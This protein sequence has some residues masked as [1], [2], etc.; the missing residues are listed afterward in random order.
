MEVE[1]SGSV[2]TLAGALPLSPAEVAEAFLSEPRQ[3]ERL[4]AYARH[5]FGIGAEECQDLIQETAYDVLRERRVV[6]NPAGFVFQVFHLRCCKHLER[7]MRR[8]KTFVPSV[9]PEDGAPAFEAPA[10]PI[11]DP[12][13]AIAVRRAM[14]SVS[15]VCQKILVAYYIEGY[16]LKEAAQE[17][18]LA[19]SG[20]FKTIN[21]CLRRLK[22][23]LD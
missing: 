17:A 2:Q 1:T 15:E 10:A 14:S 7:R 22:R 23:C 18:S 21:R 3:V 9:E 16:S 8:E 11:P 12:L 4:T 20:A 19:P 13:D 6:R 5:R